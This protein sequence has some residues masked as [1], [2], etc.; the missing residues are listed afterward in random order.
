MGRGLAKIEIIKIKNAD[1]IKPVVPYFQELSKY[2]ELE[3]LDYPNIPTLIR[4]GKGFQLGEDFTLY[5]YVCGGVVYGSAYVSKLG[6]Y[7]VFSFQDQFFLKE[8]EKREFTGVF[9]HPLLRRNGIVGKFISTALEDYDEFLILPKTKKEAAL[10]GFRVLS[11]ITGMSIEK[12]EE[13]S[14]RGTESFYEYLN[15]CDFE[16]IVKQLERYIGAVDETSV[17]MDVC[18]KKRGVFLGYSFPWFAPVYLVTR[19]QR[20]SF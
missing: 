2:E 5:M 9:V 4:G 12:I 14:F 20:E 18:A 7:S 10:E 19:T 8:I 15:K 6:K 17:P 3:W 13:I 11:E 1:Q 16:T